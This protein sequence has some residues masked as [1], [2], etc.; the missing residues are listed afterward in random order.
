MEIDFGSV[1]D[2]GF[3][4]LDVNEIVFL[5]VIDLF[6][7]VIFKRIEFMKI[8]IFFFEWEKFRD[9]CGDVIFGFYKIGRDNNF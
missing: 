7:W 6:V 3:Y 8:D 2:K 5:M 4:L 1:R 9:Y